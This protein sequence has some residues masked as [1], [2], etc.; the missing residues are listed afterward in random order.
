MSTNVRAETLVLP[1]MLTT[2]HNS[3]GP[4]GPAGQAPRQPPRSSLPRPTGALVGRARELEQLARALTAVP[5]A[6]ICGVPGVG[7]S[8]LALA[9]GATWSGPVTY[10]KLTAGMSICHIAEAIYR[11][12]GVTRNDLAVDDTERLAELWALVDELGALVVLDD[13]HCMAAESRSLVVDTAARCL[14]AGRLITASR[15]LVPIAAGTP[16]RL[17]LRLEGLSRDDAAR[18][19][20]RL[21]DLYGPGGDFEAAWRRSLGNPFLLRQGHVATLTGDDPLRAIARGLDPEEQ[22]IGGALALSHVALPRD[23][24]VRLA[25]STAAATLDKLVTRLIVDVTTV[26]EYGMHDLM[27]EAI[28][29]ELPAAAADALRAALVDA[30]SAGELDAVTVMQET[31]RHLRALGRDADIAK[32]LVATSAGLIRQGAT[33]ALLHELDAIPEGARGPE[34]Q[35]LRARA[36]ARSLL[37]TRRAYDELRPLAMRPD[38]PPA[39]R[40][41]FAT[42]ATMNGELD[43]AE[44]ALR[45]VIDG[46]DTTPELRAKAEYGRAW[47]LVY[48]GAFAETVELAHSRERAASPSGRVPWSTLCLFALISS[49]DTQAAAD[50]ASRLLDSLEA[51]PPGRPHMFTPWLCSLALARAGRFDE[52]DHALRR[53]ERGVRRP[54]DSIELSWLRTASYCERGERGTALELY[55][56]LQKPMDRS[57]YQVGVVWTRA[58]LGR[59]LLLA[60]RRREAI[61]LLS[62]TLEH[63]RAKRTLGLVPIIESAFDEDPLRSGWLGRDA[64]VPPT[65][66]GDV[67]RDQVRAAL[68][69]ACLSDGP[70][71]APDLVV[72]IPD[73]PDYAFDHALLELAR[74]VLAS[75]HGR[76]GLAATHL[77]LAMRHAAE[78]GADPDLIPALYERLPVHGPAKE[79]AVAAPLASVV[80]DCVHHEV[81]DGDVRVALVSRAVLRRLLYAFVAADGHYL[82]RNAI[83]RALWAT[84]Y[85]PLRHD[86]SLRSNIRRLRDLLEDTRVVIQTEPDGYR[87]FLPPDTTIVPPA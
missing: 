9:H 49:G 52:A 28:L 6:V 11:R 29:Q 3:V 75:R 8:T 35:L 64:A 34:I 47:V 65:K 18:L 20:D 41:F 48:R 67:V 80:I 13:L 60:G 50:L 32:L 71:T 45:S 14:H 7:K 23:I 62:E 70:Q 31:A 56:G 40:F 76:R 39:T 38:A 27:R 17:Q 16:D 57:G 30:L 42:A 33:A 43:D 51:D 1:V 15:E 81:T 36:L 24:I 72:A 58:Y 84:D 12:L 85:A 86:S 53:A 87:L 19:W 73:R 68:R 21:Q 79:A 82:D 66:R 25:P 26:A 4:V 59:L 63:C 37:Q 55:R 83:A 2:A 61:H 10:L 54:Q 78:H 44:Q 77:Q 22:R 46:D 74:A 5:V 69:G